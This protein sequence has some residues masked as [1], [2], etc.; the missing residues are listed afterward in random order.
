MAVQLQSTTARRSLNTVSARSTASEDVRGR[1]VDTALELF[2]LHGLDGMSLQML[3]DAVGLHKSSLFHHFR[4]KDE[5][6]MACLERVMTSLLVVVE[7]LE[8]DKATDVEAI[9][10]TCEDMADHFTRH[11]SA[12]LFLTR[13]LIG[14]QDAFEDSTAEQ[15]PQFFA[16]LANWLERARR[17]GA[18]RRI[19]VRHALIDLMGLVLFYPAIAGGFGQGLMGFDPTSQRATKARR[20][21]LGALVRAALKPPADPAAERPF[22]TDS[23]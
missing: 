18:I 23:A 5:L 14:S 3:A 2:A 22:Q 19:R 7:P 17:S 11:R 8:T 1:I 16:I 10:R 20:E 21:E 12:A 9:V 4:G 6:C 15:V 13:S